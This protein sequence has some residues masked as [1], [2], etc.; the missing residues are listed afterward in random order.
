MA[1][2]WLLV[3][4]SAL[5]LVASCGEASDGGGLSADALSSGDQRAGG[6]SQ[7]PNSG[8]WND[9]NP[10][11]ETNAEREPDTTDRPEVVEEEEEE[12][13]P[14]PG[15]VG[16][17]CNENSECF[18]GLCIAHPEGGYFCTKPC[19]DECPNGFLCKSTAPWRGDVMFICVP[20][21]SVICQGCVNDTDCGGPKHRCMSIGSAEESLFCGRYCDSDTDCPEGYGCQ[22]GETWDGQVARQCLPLTGS[23]ICDEALNQTTRPCSTTNEW[24][25]CYGDELCDGGA[26]WSQCSAQVPAIEIC[27]GA[28]NDCDGDAD[29]GHSP[30]PCIKENAFGTC[31]GVRSCQGVEGLI[32]D[33]LEPQEELCDGIDNNCDGHIDEDFVD[34]DA[35]GQ[36]D[37]TDEDDDNDG[38]A[39]ID[40]NCSLIANANQNDLDADGEGDL[41]DLDD[42]GDGIVDTLD[43]CPTD[44]N[45]APIDTDDD[46]IDDDC[47]DDDDGDGSPDP[48]DCAPTDA[49]VSPISVELC[50]GIDNNCNASTD[51]AFADTDGD[52]QADCVD[53]DDDGDG[54]PDVS[55]CQPLNALI[56][57]TVTELCDAID[58]DCD[59]AIDEIFSDEDDNG[60]LDCVTGDLDGDGDPD[61]VDCA[62]Y[63]SDIGHGLPDVCN[64]VDDDCDGITD[65][66]QPDTDNDGLV[67]CVDIDDDND[68][69]PDISDCAP[70]DSSKSPLALE[71]CNGVDDNCNDAVDEGFADMDD[72]GIADCADEDDDGDGIN[73]AVD[74]CPYIPDPLQ[75]DTDG[76]GAGDPCDDDADAD[77]VPDIQDNCPL[78]ANAGQSDW[79]G[80]GVGDVCDPDDD[81]DGVIDEADCGPFDPDTNPDADEVCDGI[82]NNCD[83]DVDSEFPD[84]DED[85]FSNCVDPDD[86]NDGDPDISDCEPFD[87]AYHANAPE[88]CDGVDNNCK[89][90]IDE[91][92][93]DLDDDGIAD[94]VDPDKDGD[95]LLD[96]LDNCPNHPNPEQND[97]DGDGL[98]DECDPVVPGPLHHI[99]VRDAPGLLGEIVEDRL[100]LPG[101]EALVLYAVG[102]D[103]QGLYIGEQSVMWN[104]TGSLEDVD[105][106]P[107]TS[108]TFSP[109]EPKTTGII[110]AIPEDSQ[111]VFPGST[112]TI[113]VGIP[114]VGPPDMVASTIAVDRPVLTIGGEAATIV[115]R[116]ADT[117]GSPV[118]EAHDVVVTTSAGQLQGPLV[119]LGNGTYEQTLLAGP[120]PATATLSATV[121]GQA[122][123]EDISVD[124]IEL[125]APW[126]GE[127]IDCFNYPEYAGQNLFIEDTDLFIAS[128]GCAPMVFGH[129]IISG[130]GKLSTRNPSAA[131]IPNS[132]DIIVDSLTLEESS[133]IDVSCRGYPGGYWHESATHD[134]SVGN[135]VGGSHGGLGLAGSDQGEVTAP[136][137]GVFGQLREPRH[138]GG[139]GS[140]GNG[141]GLIRIVTKDTGSVV[142]HG[143]IKANGCNHGSGAGAGGGVFIQT[144]SFGGSGRIEAFGGAGGNQSCGEGC[145]DGGGGGGGGRV[146][147]TGYYALSG[148]F[149]DEGIYAHVDVSGGEGSTGVAGAG[150][151]FLQGVMDANGDLIISNQ[152]K[153][154]APWST[155]LLS[156]GKGSTHTASATELQDL[157]QFWVT[158]L[159]KGHTLNPNVDQG[160]PATM[161]DDI[162]VTLVGNTESA[163]LATG[164]L[165]VS[166]PGDTYRSVHVFDNLEIQGGASVTTAGGDLLV[167]HGDRSSGDESTLALRGDLDVNRL[168]L[169]DGTA[170]EVNQGVTLHFESL[171]SGMSATAPLDIMVNEGSVVGSDLHSAELEARGAT[172]VLNTLSSTKDVSL[173]AGSSLEI[174]NATIDVGGTLMMAGQSSI[175]QPISSEEE[176]FMLDISAA[177][178]SIEPGSS[179]SADASGYPTGIGHGTLT[180]SVPTGYAGGSHGGLGG[181]SAEGQ[182]ALTYGDIYAPLTSGGV[183]RKEP[184]VEVSS[185][186]R[187][188]DPGLTRDHQ[189]RWRVLSLGWRSRRLHR[190]EVNVPLERASSARLAGTEPLTNPAVTGAQRRAALA[191]AGA[192]RFTAT[193]P[194]STGSLPRRC[195]SMCWLSAV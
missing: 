52:G 154:S 54:D 108:L 157:N 142:I 30:S 24:G 43:S 23:C 125:E 124:I 162:L 161:V 29:E 42:D 34:T 187:V 84:F 38:V 80:D 105:P 111:N 156:V 90:G 98:G 27:D 185:D 26:G 147:I 173:L 70:E 186:G 134:E 14:Q 22:D 78:D 130:G 61:G 50:D 10:G 47:D 48:L 176:N 51:E 183:R 72:D 81:N 28:D 121:D 175:T 195:M 18:S 17:Q 168:D 97:L 127:I 190:L 152:G 106:G 94:C 58:N 76:D 20:E 128:H 182:A 172:L 59:N 8:T 179:I 188:R 35:D 2:R 164:G 137:T 194:S 138:P 91:G 11:G 75:I 120:T 71:V 45:P 181:K 116:L 67:N 9:P 114:E 40:D 65:P 153:S 117:W 6:G 79:D 158:N 139:G 109:L 19:D 160:N 135:L 88:L 144:P 92:Y 148:N 13:I 170:I 169:V 83:G 143:E 101:E 87:S 5:L 21:I 136:S 4:L 191:A 112:G 1:S 46:G 55:D 93:A 39:D 193:S 113:T 15:E 133:T 99:E 129:I 184:P 146:A 145:V 89:L 3:F 118:T 141:G 57:S 165:D 68:G 64:G 149:A 166:A 104:A 103:N 115:V 132:I 171:I 7:D 174:R 107:S 32:C 41:C 60:I 100:L 180:S 123:A 151:L 82:D 119:G 155:P 56:G 167:Y 85:G 62:P 25:T 95:G 77:G 16:S 12:Y 163:L 178:V 73:D 159:F 53:E 74:V 49:L 44:Y 69:S 31:H 131:G 126:D 33:A 122:L 189:R 66:G 86:D 110:F 36:A 102:F 140:Y 96:E 63:D 192:S 150:T 37:C 177:L